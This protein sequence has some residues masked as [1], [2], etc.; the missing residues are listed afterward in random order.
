MRLEPVYLDPPQAPVLKLHERDAFQLPPA[1]SAK[2]RLET[3][4]LA[5]GHPSGYDLDVGDFVRELE[6]H[7]RRLLAAT[8][9]IATRVEYDR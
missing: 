4:T 8:D 2:L 3:S 6:I 5:H 9:I 1:S 7:A